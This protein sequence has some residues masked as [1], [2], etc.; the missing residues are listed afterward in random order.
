MGCRTG[1]YLLVRDSVTSEDAILLVQESMR[2]IAA[3]EGEIPGNTSI[4][5]GNY[6]EHDL[7]QAKKIAEDMARVLAGWKVE[8]LRY[9][10]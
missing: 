3:F 10:E 2:F 7:P 1:F 5:C 9:K 4:E 8:D 6:L